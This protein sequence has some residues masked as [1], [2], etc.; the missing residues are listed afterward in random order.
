MREGSKFSGY[1]NGKSGIPQ[2]TVALT[3]GVSL[4]CHAVLIGILFFLP[5]YNRPAVNPFPSSINVSLV[6][7]PAGR[8]GPPAGRPDAI[9]SSAVA[10]K[11]AVK[12]ASI[13]VEKPKEI[14]KPAVKA[15]KV[16]KKPPEKVTKAVSLNPET[17]PKKKADSA[18]LI[19]NAVK[20]MEK[21]VGE[22]RPASVSDA[23][24]KIRNQIESGS[25]TGKFDKTD[26][27]K[28]YGSQG[29]GIKGAAPGLPGGSGGNNL[30]IGALDIYNAEI[31]YI[32]QQNW[33][34]SEQIG[35]R[36]SDSVVALVIKI[37]RTGEISDIRFESRSQNRHLDESAYR[38]IQKSNP[39]PILP[40]GYGRPY[41]EVG[42]RFGTSG[43]KQK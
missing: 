30:P 27:A 18:E 12:K 31:S 39:L 1:I 2:K 16:Q 29:T 11:K 42:L 3:F 33:A 32:I 41:Y 17:L 25:K 37:M 14:S 43:L 15:E 9:K 34:Y 23:I 40:E 8:P 13:K 20:D 22:S 4:A 6:S 21:K 5:G 26:Q 35:G 24:S 38:A 19:K 36:G 10:E 28:G 7:L